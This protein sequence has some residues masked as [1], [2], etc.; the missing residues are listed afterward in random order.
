VP[1]QRHDRPDQPAD[2][3][4]LASY[5]NYGGKT[6]ISMVAPGGDFAVGNV[7]DLILSACSRFVTFTDCA[8]SA[9]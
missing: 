3:D 6:G 9:S 7:V 1:A 5:S 4:L 2:F 8:S